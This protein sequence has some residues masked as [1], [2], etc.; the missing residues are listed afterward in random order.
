MCSD[1]LWFAIKMKLKSCK[2]LL[3]FNFALPKGLNDH[4]N[5]NGVSGFPHGTPETVLNK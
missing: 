5:I 2:M 3:I 4:R 1:M